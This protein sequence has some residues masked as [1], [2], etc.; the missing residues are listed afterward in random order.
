MA[1]GSSTWTYDP[2]TRVWSGPDTPPRFRTNQSVGQLVLSVLKQSEPAH[3]SQLSVDIDGGR[4]VTCGEMY[5][6]TV[7]IAQHL[8][9]LGYGRQGTMAAL[10]SRNGEHV[11]PVMFACLALGMPVN[12]LD[13]AFTAA[14]FGHML[15]ITRPALVFCESHIL[16]T[17]RDGAASVGIDPAYVL[18]EGHRDGFRHVDELLEPTGTEESFVAPELDDPANSLAVILCSS[19][20]TGRPKGVCYTHRFCLVNLPSLW[21]MTPSDSVLAFSS[22]YWLSGFAALINGT[23]S[24]GTRVITRDPFEPGRTLDILQR[25]RVTHGFFSPYQTNL[26]VSEPDLEKRDLSAFRMLLCGGARVSK[27]LYHALRRRLPSHTAILI[28]YGMSESSLVTLTDG[29]TYR[30]DCVGTVQARTEVKIVDL[31]ELDGAEATDAEER[32]LPPGQSG[33]IM[34]R[35]QVPFAGY[36][37]DAEATANTIGPDGWI[38]TGDIGHIDADGLLYIVDRKKD[39]IKYAGFQISPAELEALIRLVPGVLDCCVVGVPVEGSDLP[40]VLVMRAPGPVGASLEP[41]QVEQHVRE[42]VA[43]CKRLRGGVYFA[44]ELP[45]TPS[46]KVMRRKCLE[47]VLEQARCTNGEAK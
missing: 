14:D 26:I 24:L 34:V 5:Q 12:T 40:A 28:G 33:E 19:G 32:P 43:D 29:Y 6:R 20:T 8:V 39:I 18:F 9:R 31:T 11:A 38:R 35:V 45:L 16:E 36:Y 23:L 22:L 3:P 21:H 37:G 4:V 1:N 30:D 41:A 25:H 27:E 46:G 17:V 42:R 47:L 15:G 13:P 44:P 10:A 7:R 2:V